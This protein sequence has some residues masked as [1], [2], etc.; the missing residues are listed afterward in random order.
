MPHIISLWAISYTGATWISLVAG[1]RPEVLAVGNLDTALKRAAEA[2]DQLCRI[3]LAECPLWPKFAASWDR[4][5]NFLTQLAEASGASQIVVRNPGSNE[6]RAMLDDPSITVQNVAV[7]RDPRPLAASWMRKNPGNDVFT[8]LEKWLIPA[9]ERMVSYLDKPGAIVIDHAVAA[10]DFGYLAQKLEEATGLSYGNEEAQYWKHDHHMVAGNGGT[11][12]TVIAYQQ[13]KE[14]KQEFYAAQMK[15]GLDAEKPKFVDERWRKELTPFDIFAVERT[16]GETGL[17]L[18][19]TPE[20]FGSERESF[21]RRLQ[22]EIARRDVPLMRE[23][24][25]ATSAPTGGLVGRVFSAF[26]RNP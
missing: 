3:H 20:D 15:S 13:G 7:K 8:A 24:L 17:R 1:S 23:R 11:F 18:G 10:Q 14:H 21:E 25:A 16:L 22:E 12:G 4:N 19:L 6:A 9:A 2:P 5:G 26:R